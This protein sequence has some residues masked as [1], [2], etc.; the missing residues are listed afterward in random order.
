MSDCE[1]DLAHTTGS[2]A[3]MFGL[4]RSILVFVPGSISL[5]RVEFLGLSVTHLSGLVSPCGGLPKR[6][7]NLNVCRGLN[8]FADL[9]GVGAGRSW[10][11]W[12][13]PGG[14]AWERFTQAASMGGRRPSQGP[15]PLPAYVPA[16]PGTATWSS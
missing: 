2:D 12:S 3:P 14:L 10:G 7:S 11:R 6:S 13:S 16:E 8:H 15:G 5:D 9:G 4:P 1:H